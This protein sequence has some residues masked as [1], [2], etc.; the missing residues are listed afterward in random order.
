MGIGQ[1]AV[2]PVSI[3]LISDM[4]GGGDGANVLESSASASMGTTRGITRRRILAVF[5]GASVLYV[6]VYVG[7]AVSGQIATAFTATQSGWRTALRAIGITGIVM[8]VVLRVVLREPSRKSSLVKAGVLLRDVKVDAA[9]MEGVGGAQRGISSISAA[10]VQLRGTVS[11]VVRLRSFWLLVLS[12][13]FR[14]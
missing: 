1:A 8:A 9:A 4:R 3:S 10:R 7:E 11:Y 6:G 14:Q 5:M 13:S 12:A 2:A